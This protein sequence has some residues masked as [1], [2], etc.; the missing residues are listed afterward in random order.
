[1]ADLVADSVDVGAVLYEQPRHAHV[2][3]VS[4]NMQWTE[5]AL[6]RLKS[7]QPCMVNA[8]YTPL[9]CR[10]PTEVARPPLVSVKTLVFLPSETAAH[11]LS[12]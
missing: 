7:T 3:V 9:P 4:G 11:L 6:Q 8:L 10:P 5:A 12:T 1:M 2:A